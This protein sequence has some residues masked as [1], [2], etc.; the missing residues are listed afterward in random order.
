VRVFIASLLFCSLL[1]GQ[2]FASIG[3]YGD[4]NSDEL[5]VANLVKSWNPDF[6]ITLG[7]N[8]YNEGLW[9]TIDNNIG[10][11]YHEFI[12]PYVGTYGQGSDINRFF[13]S[14]GNHDHNNVNLLQPYLDYFDLLPYS[15]SS[16]NERY[17]DFIWGNIH[18]FSVNSCTIE[19]DG[20]TH[21]S[22]Q[23]AWLEAQLANCD[24]NH[25]HWK[26]V[27][28]HH[29]AYS[30][31]QHGS[32]TRMQWPFKE[33][34]ADVVMSGHD[35]T[36]ERINIDDFLYF[37]NGLG[38]KSKYSFDPPI[39][40]SEVRYNDK[41]GAMLMEADEFTFSFSFFSVDS[42][43]IDYYQLVKPY[44]ATPGN[45]IAQIFTEPL[46]V[47]LMW[48]D[49]SNNEDGFVI[50]RDLTNS[51]V[52]EVVD[53]VG[54]DVTNYLD[55]TITYATYIYRIKAFNQFGDSPYSDT[56]EVIVPVELISFTAHLVDN[57]VLL[58][59]VTATELNNLGFEVL[60]NLENNWTTIGFV[61]GHGSSSVLNNYKFSD[62][63]LLSGKRNLY[64]LKQIDYS[65]SFVYSNSIEVFGP[66]LSYVLGQNFPNP[67][68][69]RTTIR[70]EI[71]EDGIVSIKLYDIF[72][73]EVKTLLNEYMKANIYE[74][75]IE[76]ADLSSGV[77][78]YKL[79]TNKFSDSKK[80]ILLK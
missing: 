45:L 55:T 26:V 67:F 68:N 66:A 60:K 40:G 59:W 7:D 36:Y 4:D 53:T 14:P 32:E 41:Y 9:A 46:F 29:A 12:F 8:N 44:P 64:R 25:S 58:E 11:Y 13:P 31:G 2:R 18:F 34:G 23:S 10:Q 72:G 71:P 17:Y 56:A 22:V 76:A 77:Y 70:F 15:T 28:F 65:G 19:P 63:N 48:T 16:G 50:E 6:I 52:F 37:V 30:S 38:G 78:F 51:D 61:D 39:P 75:N 43:L 74:I 3:D 54:T 57:T 27:F 73:Q 1:F 80:M 47:E 49:N 79:Q 35:H 21:P 42:E 20:Y 62:N 69:P 5:A 33:W 24:S